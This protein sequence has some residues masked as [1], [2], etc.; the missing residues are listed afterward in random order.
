MILNI[1][2]S[3]AHPSCLM[4]VFKIVQVLVA[5]INIGYEDIVNTQV[6]KYLSTS[7]GLLC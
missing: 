3:L 2:V 4:Y 6:R 5:D 1:S 7:I